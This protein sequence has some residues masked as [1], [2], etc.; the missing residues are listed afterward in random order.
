[1]FSCATCSKRG[2]GAAG[3]FEW[4]M[5]AQ[6]A[7]VLIDSDL[8]GVLIYAEKAFRRRKPWRSSGWMHF[9]ARGRLSQPSRMGSLM[10]YSFNLR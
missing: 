5:G 6:A 2:G 4:H 8:A 9:A 1:M 10:P 3:C 7:R